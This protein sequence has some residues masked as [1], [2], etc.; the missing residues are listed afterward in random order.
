MAKYQI[1]QP[2]FINGTH[3]DASVAAPA[4]I[5][6]PDD[7]PPSRTWIPLDEAA[8]KAQAKL[9]EY[10]ALPQAEKA[11]LAK[12]QAEKEKKERFAAERAAAR[13]AAAEAP[14]IAAPAR[15]TRANDKSPV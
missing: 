5:T 2:A 9:A 11:K 14:A 7:T 8:D 4:V 12:A 6:L 13:A 15:T 3:Y 10:D 1:S